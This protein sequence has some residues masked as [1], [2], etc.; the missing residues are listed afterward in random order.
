MA[1]LCQKCCVSKHLSTKLVFHS[2]ALFG[3]R[4]Y[5]PAW[6]TRRPLSTLSA[7]LAS[8]FNSKP[9][10][11]SFN[12]RSGCGLFQI[13]ELQDFTGFHFL[14]DKTEV[15]VESL[16]REITSPNRTKSVVTLFDELSDCLCRVADMAD[17]IRVSH[18]DPSFAQAAEDACVYLSGIVEKLNT[19]PDIY[20]ALK[21]AVEDGDVV[22]LDE[23]DKRVGQLFLFDHEQCGIHLSEEKRATFVK[24][25]EDVMMIGNFFMQGTHVMRTVKKTFLPESIRFY[26]NID[27]DH[28]QVHNLHSDHHNERMREAAYKIYLYPDKHQEHLLMS[29][30]GCRHKLAQVV[31]F[32]T[33]AH[34]TIKG[35]MASTPE[36]VM[37]F[38]ENLADRIRTRADAD[39]ADM[40]RLKQ[41][42]GVM[43]D[44]S[45]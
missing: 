7:P 11:F 6:T 24:L 34:R 41:T 2:R 18:P 20:N 16:V 36:N 17:F 39:Y 14:K 32:E 9:A 31:G 26:F 8:A 22:P 28:V 3:Q 13:M 4:K 45:I 19:N 30:L 44:V 25:N 15:E 1:A 10:K 33:Y 5:S 38:L 40:L 27:G 23:Q 29:L 37:D 12:F 21:T 42:E 43:E 35:T